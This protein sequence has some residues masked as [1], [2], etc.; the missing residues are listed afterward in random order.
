MLEEIIGVV[1]NGDREIGR[2][3]ENSADLKAAGVA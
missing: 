3:A 1:E 2:I